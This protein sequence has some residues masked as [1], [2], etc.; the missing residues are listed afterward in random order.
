MIVSLPNFCIR[1]LGKKTRLFHRC[2]LDLIW[3]T[4]PACMFHVHKSDNMQNYRRS[5]RKLHLAPVPGLRWQPWT[6]QRSIIVDLGLQSEAAERWPIT[7]LLIQLFGNGS[8]ALASVPHAVISCGSVV[9]FSRR[10]LSELSRRE[11]AS[12][13]ASWRD[14]SAAP[15]WCLVTGGRRCGCVVGDWCMIHMTVEFALWKRCST[16]E[17]Y[18]FVCRCCAA[19]A[20]LF[21]GAPDRQ[22]QWV[23]SS[24]C[25]F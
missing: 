2:C 5:I 10:L 9:V 25:S 17:Y 21:F 14:W 16:C 8:P 7:P 19:Q 11:T 15:R 18:M 13:R 24:G 1:W 23:F 12:S 22:P 4:N 6:K 3:T 20:C